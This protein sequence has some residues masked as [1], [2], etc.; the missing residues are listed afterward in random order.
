[1]ID[2][3]KTSAQSTGAKVVERVAGS[4]IGSHTT[5]EFLK[6][7]LG[8]LIPKDRVVKR[9]AC[10]APFCPRQNEDEAG[11]TTMMNFWENKAG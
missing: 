11:A 4:I 1:M 2:N 9:N 10:D 3:C 7:K 5:F 8:G 6:L